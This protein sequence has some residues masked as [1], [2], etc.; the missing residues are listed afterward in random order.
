MKKLPVTIWLLFA[1]TFVRAQ[2]ITQITKKPDSCI[3]T[4][5]TILRT[6]CKSYTSP[7]KKYTWTKTDHYRDTILSKGG[8]DSVI[9][10]NLV[11]T[12]KAD[13]SVTQKGNTLTANN[14]FNETPNG[15]KFFTTFFA[16][17]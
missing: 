13:T 2:S 16:G 9:M 4:S 12:G 11:I 17:K 14:G 5:S 15:F 10:V 6:A 8:C 7:S 1:I 3:S